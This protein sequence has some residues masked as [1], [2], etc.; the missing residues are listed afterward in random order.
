MKFK[1][2]LHI[3]RGQTDSYDTSGRILHSDTLKAALFA[4]AKQLLPSEVTQDATWFHRSYQVSSAFPFKGDE[5]FFPKPKLKLPFTIQGMEEARYAK[6]FK[7][8][9]YIGKTLFENVL[10]EIQ[11][12]IHP[13]QIA[14]NGNYLFSS[15]V[16]QNTRVM[17]S[18]VQQ[19]VFIP[20]D[21]EKPAQP[22]Y[23]DR[24]YFEEDAG[25]F[26][27]LETDHE[28]TKDHILS[29]L[30][31]LGDEGIGTDRSSGNGMFDFTEDTI[32]LEVPGKADKMMN[33]SLYIPEKEELTYD[34]LQEGA[35]ELTRRGGYIAGTGESEFLKLRKRQIFMMQEGSVFANNETRKGKLVNL[36]PAYQGVHDV[37]R[38]GTALFVPL[39]TSL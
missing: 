13:R 16:D 4:M 32:T 11:T 3:S 14:D 10:K 6:S 2:P 35:W 5:L 1:A 33:L 25:L 21:Y 37:W 19:K 8:V 29:C 15:A 36:K 39:K 38:D 34:H 30:Q 17:T 22:Y 12:E 9:E 18:D 7:K 31:L 28:E 24:I 23:I 20:A 26:F 27:L